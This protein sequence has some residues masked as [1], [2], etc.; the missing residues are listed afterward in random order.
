MRWLRDASIV[1]IACLGMLAG[2]AAYYGPIDAR[3]ESGQRRYELVLQL[4]GLDYTWAERPTFAPGESPH[5][6]VFD[7]GRGAADV[8]YFNALVVRGQTYQAAWFRG[9][10]PSSTDA[11]PLS[12]V[13]D[14]MLATR[15]VYIDYARLGMLALLP[16]LFLLVRSIAR[17]PMVRHGTRVVLF[18]ILRPLARALADAAP[19]LLAML[20]TNGG[21]CRRCGYDLRATPDRC[22]E[23]G[24]DISLRHQAPA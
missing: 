20:E 19:R 5:T 1:I 15:R 3:W 17:S 14:F 2:Y 24:T 11:R 16:L 6:P 18:P 21:R 4:L 8:A 7:D 22:P 9:T 23:C 13:P 10:P 12:P